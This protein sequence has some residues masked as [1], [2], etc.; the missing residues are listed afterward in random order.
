VFNRLRDKAINS[1]NQNKI[2]AFFNAP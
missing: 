1:E 2:E